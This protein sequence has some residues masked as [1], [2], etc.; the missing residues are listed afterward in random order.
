MISASLQ[1]GQ[2]GKASYT[3]E[4]HGNCILIFGAVPA[5]AF[6]ALTRLVPKKAVMD[7]QLARIAGCSL[8]MGLLK[9]TKGLIAELSPA[10]VEISR[11][12]YAGTG[13]SEA[14]IQ[15]LG[16]GERGA[17]SDA[18]FLGLTG[19]RPI[20]MVGEATAYPHDPDDLWRCRLLLEQ[21]PELNSK[22]PDLRNISPIWVRLVASWDE[23]CRTM[24]AE[25]PYWREGK[26][27][28]GQTYELLQI[29]E[30]GE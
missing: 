26:G 20:D 14:A 6:A 1:M 19:I 18:M 5:S 2:P 12:N 4:H 22:L 8:A 13:L 29:A 11:R 21:V 23:L 16:V 9:D 7:A 17:S 24:D 3:V 27:R 28:A 15:W 30:A 10:A 25:S